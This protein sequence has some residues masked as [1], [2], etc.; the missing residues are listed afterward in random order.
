MTEELDN[1]LKL[2]LGAIEAGHIL[3]AD[4]HL[5]VLANLLG[6]GRADIEDTIAA[7]THAS[8]HKEID[9]DKEQEGP[10]HHH[11][12]AK[13]LASLLIIDRDGAVFSL[14]NGLAARL[15]AVDAGQV[16]NEMG[17]LARHRHRARKEVLVILDRIRHESDLRLKII[18][19]DNNLVNALT[20]EQLGLKSAIGEGVRRAAGEDGANAHK[21]YGHD[22]VDPIGVKD[23]LPVLLGIE[24]GHVCV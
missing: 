1:L 6:L 5:R 16:D 24:V 14:L 11:D 20:A 17:A 18:A 8:E 9:A 15:E 23:H 12:I 22:A 19:D 3:E 13:E 7:T 10:D 4:I 21:D 2:L